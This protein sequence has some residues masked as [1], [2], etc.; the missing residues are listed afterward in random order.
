MSERKIRWWIRK[1]PTLVTIIQLKHILS[2]T[3]LCTLSDSFAGNL[4]LCLK[5]AFQL[6]SVA[7]RS[8]PMWRVGS[9]VLYTTHIPNPRKCVSGNIS[10]FEMVRMVWALTSRLWIHFAL[11]FYVG[12]TVF[13]LQLNLYICIAWVTKLPVTF[14]K[15]MP[16]N[17]LK[18]LLRG[19]VTKIV[20]LWREVFL[21]AVLRVLWR[22]G[23][24]AL[25]TGYPIYLLYSRIWASILPAPK[26]IL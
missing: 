7:K 5:V 17:K 25:K 20:E 10:F 16:L 9:F 14:E 19:R 18:I 26:V 8:V 15:Q 4:W 22:T 12:M 21:N 3:I 1:L 6:T 13:W 23:L 24:A 11:N 2:R